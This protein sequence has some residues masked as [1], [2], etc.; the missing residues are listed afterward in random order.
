VKLPNFHF[1]LICKKGTN[2]Y[3]KCVRYYLN[4]SSA[5]VS[6]EYDGK[7]ATNLLTGGR[8]LSKENTQIGAWDLLI[9]EEDD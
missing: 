3:G 6:L 7:D 2:D 8:L 1:P 9:V 5:P 4:Y